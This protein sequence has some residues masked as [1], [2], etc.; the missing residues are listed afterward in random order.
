[1]IDG[2]GLL[3]GLELAHGRPVQFQPIGIV[4]NAIEDSVGESRV[5]DDVVPFISG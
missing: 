1:M 4:D 5:A 3:G 2:F